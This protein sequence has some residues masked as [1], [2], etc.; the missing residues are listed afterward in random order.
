MSFLKNKLKELKN[1]PTPENTS[2]P[3]SFL[4]DVV[5]QGAKIVEH[6]RQEVIGTS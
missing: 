2:K 4:A 3:M 5:K 1:L 6:G